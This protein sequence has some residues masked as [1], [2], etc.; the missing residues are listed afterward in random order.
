MEKQRIDSQAEKDKLGGSRETEPLAQE[1]KVIPLMRK[2][3]R[4]KKSHIVVFREDD[5]KD[6]R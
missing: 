3:G 5:E 6:L 2:R 1:P 4:G